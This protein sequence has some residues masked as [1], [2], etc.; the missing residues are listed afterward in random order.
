MD[1]TYPNQLLAERAKAWEAAKEIL[2]RCAQDKRE[3]TSEENV[4]FERANADIDRL[5]REVQEWTDSARQAK[6]NDVARSAFESILSPTVE[7]SRTQNAMSSIERYF[8][9]EGDKTFDVN[10]HSAARVSQAI[11]A[12]ADADEVRGIFTDGGSSGGSLVVPVAFER[13]LYQYIEASS[14]IRRISYVMTTDSGNAMTFPKVATHGVG[15]QVVAQ[16]T[17]IGGTDPVFGTI[18]LDSYKYGQ[19]VR[20]S[21][22][23]I[24]DTGFDLLGFIAQNIGRAIG[25]ITDT[26]YVTGGGSTNPNGIITAASVGAKTGGSLLTLTVENLIDLQHSV[27]DEYRANGAFVMNDLTA[28]TIRKIR[29]GAGGTVG[30]FIW[31]PSTTFAGVGPMAM[32]DRL[33]G[34]SAYT[35]VNFGTQGSA[36]KSVAYGDFSAYYIRDSGAFRFE[37]SDDRYFD[38][39][40]VGFR[41]VLRTDS[42]LIDTGAV[43]LLQQ[44]A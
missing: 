44:L 10:L 40:E 21:T 19:L 15:T 17:A 33:L 16:G 39:D 22:E 7:A 31:T 8:R 36:V 35:D 27:V 42:D 29:D 30:S 28:G 41:G 3:R 23:A 25:R 5:G 37:R 9:G 24:S 2:D 4:M 6:E 18:R 26:A 12:G 14:A 32:P 11:R 38:T 1:T 43:K 34:S 13:T 20:V